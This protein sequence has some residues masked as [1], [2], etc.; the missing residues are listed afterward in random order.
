[1]PA[2]SEN[3]VDTLVNVSRKLRTLFDARAKLHG[4]TLSRARLIVQLAREDGL[5][6]VQLAQR[7]DVEQPSIVGLV[8]ALQKAGMVERRAEG[9]DRRARHVYLTPAAQ[10]TASELLK[11]LAEIRKE[12]LEGIPATELAHATAT[13]TH[14]LKNID[15]AAQE[16]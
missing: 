10:G 16:K 4:L 5:T 7:L 6:Q 1:M 3:F 2:T 14:V 9:A 13:L 12:C 15:L 8:D 11:Y